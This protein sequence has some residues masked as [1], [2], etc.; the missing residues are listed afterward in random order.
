MSSIATSSSLCPYC[1]WFW[2]EFSISTIHIIASDV[3]YYQGQTVLAA[4]QRSRQRFTRHGVDTK[5]Y[6]VW[7][8]INSDI[9]YLQNGVTVVIKWSLIIIVHDEHGILCFAKG[10]IRIYTLIILS[11]TDFRCVKII[12]W[13]AFYVFVM[14]YKSSDWGLM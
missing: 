6:I 4:K 14:F 10:E 1:Y 11:T 2:L 13:Q 5:W 9:L 8:D 12:E 3:R 7:S